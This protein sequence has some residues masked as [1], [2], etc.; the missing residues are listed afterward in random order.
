MTNRINSNICLK[1]LKNCHMNLQKKRSIYMRDGWFTAFFICDFKVTG[2]SKIRFF[3]GFA[4]S[5]NIRRLVRLKVH[6]IYQKSQGKPYIN[7]TN[8]VTGHFKVIVTVF[9]SGCLQIGFGVLI[10]D[11]ICNF[12]IWPLCYVLRKHQLLI[13]SLLLLDNSPPPPPEGLKRKYWVGDL[14]YP[15]SPG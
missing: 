8:W 14:D 2:H 15:P 9:S 10:I 13:G 3:V 6:V 4:P 7:K 5:V 1:K 12:L 11:H